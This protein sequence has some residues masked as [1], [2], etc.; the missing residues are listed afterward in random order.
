MHNMKILVRVLFLCLISHFVVGQSIEKQ[1]Q[2]VLD[3]VYKKNTDATGIMIHVESP[4]NHI[5]WT[6]AVGVSNKDTNALLHKNQTVLIASNTKTYVATAILKL[7]ENKKL[8]LNQSI[9]VLLNSE[10]AEGFSSSGYDLNGITIKHLLSHT[11]GINDYVTDDYFEFVKENPKYQWTRTEQ[12]N[13]SIQLGKPYAKAGAEFKYGDINYVL[14]TEIIENIT[15]QPF[16]TAI[17][18]LINYNRVRLNNTWFINLEKQ[19]EI[20]NSL[21]HQYSNKHYWD[22]Y[23]LNPLWDLYGGGGLVSTTKEMALFFQALFEGRIIKDKQLV[24][25][26]HSYVLPKEESNYCLG[27][28][29]ISFGDY[30]AY[31]HGGFWGTDVMYLPEIN[32]SIAVVTLEKDKRNT[33]SP[34]LSKKVLSI[35]K[36]NFV[37]K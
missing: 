11:S 15:K 24:K 7:V 17:R 32:T 18:E 28:R 26:M 35:L 9:R 12:I 21:V 1:F 25:E 23:N 8:Q 20:A 5:S 30:E 27:L 13:K 22:S 3:S 29:N 37:N 16:Y 10:I 31:Y 14:L 34:I 36:R 33:I 19:P 4:D 6:S 2:K